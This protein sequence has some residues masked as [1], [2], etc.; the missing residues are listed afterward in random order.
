MATTKRQKKVVLNGVSKQQAEEAMKEYA[1][2]Y[3]EK[4]GL[5][6]EMDLR[7]AE[8]RQEYAKQ[9]EDV[10]NRMKE[11][12]ELMNAYANEN[13]D[14]EFSKKKSMELMHGTIGYRTGTPKL[15]TMK[16]FTW[17]S[18]TTLAARLLPGL[19]MR[20]KEPEIAKDMILADRNEEHVTL[21]S[22]DEG[23]MKDALE[24]CGMYVVQEDTFYVEPK[25]EI[26]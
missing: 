25:T 14:Q 7:L 16:G 21:L 18:C 24:R 17:A 22:G 11:S 5:A 15:K 19:Y 23:S 26:R 8:V 1:E 9:L 2:A 20:T 6:A 13:R 12:F 10:D 3:A 4:L